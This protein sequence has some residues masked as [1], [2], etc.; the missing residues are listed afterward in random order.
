MG[1]TPR[2]SDWALGKVMAVLV[3]FWLTF[4]TYM[5]Q[6]VL[7]TSCPYLFFFLTWEFIAVA[8]SLF[9][10]WKLGEWKGNA[11]CLFNSGIW[12]E[13]NHNWGNGVRG[14]F[15]PGPHLVDK[16]LHQAWDGCHNGYILHT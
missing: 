8:L 16:N 2:D 5:G 6:W 10:H 11:T 3:Y 12:T 7:G 14:S 9:Q 15:M 1:P 13:K 4:R